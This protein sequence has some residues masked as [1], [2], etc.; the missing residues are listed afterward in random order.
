MHKNRGQKVLSITIIL[1]LVVFLAAPILTLFGRAFQN[2]DGN[3]VGMENFTNYIGTRGFKVSL[4]NSLKV[5]TVATLIAMILAFI[6]AYAVNRTNIKCK[7]LFHWIAL[8][9]LFAPT[10]THGIALIYLFGKKGL[11]TNAL[12][13]N[14]DIYGF[15]G[16][17][18]SESLYIFPVVYLMMSLALKNTD[19]RLYEAAEIMG[20]SSLKQFLTITLPS[21]KFT[22]ITAFFS[23]FTMA[24]TDFGA[25]KIVGGNYSVLATEVYK[26]LL[27]QQ[28]LEMGSVVGVI[29]I[30]PAIIAFVVDYVVGKKNKMQVDSKATY[31]IIKKNKVRDTS[32]G[33]ISVLIMMA[34]IMIFATILMS[35]L[36]TNWP[37]ELDITTKWF[38]FSVMGISGFEIFRNSIL[39]A[40]AT[41]VI[42][43]VICFFA[44]YISGRKVSLPIVDKIIYFLGILPNAVPGLTIGI[45]YMFFFNKMNNPLKF[46]YG[47]FAILIFANIIHFFATPF[48]TIRNEMRRIDSEYE[49]VSEVMGV[50]W[51]SL[52]KR[53]IIPI[54]MPAI[55]ESFSYYFVNSMMTVSA[56]VFLYFPTT[57]LATISMIN[58]ADIGEMAAASAVA[59]M[60]FITNIIFRYMF[61]RVTEFLRDKEERKKQIA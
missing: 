47:T 29:L 5:S 60:I 38:S 15:W 50:P 45:A 39:V 54:S 21:V 34:I 28:D 36:V 42:G 58:K 31:Y 53:V 49:N 23:A 24:F 61:N 44:A 6:Y 52:L 56:V 8:F 4:F 55:L 16:I 48:L 43:T 27:G 13:L 37:Y 1:F 20:T 9:P 30:I 14:F 18:I 35:S 12:N 33:I 25:P 22:L 59:V 46:I 2:I 17:T 26:K 41:A 3:F 32:V 10:M 40:F 51:Y 11:L 7:S 57:R 19:N